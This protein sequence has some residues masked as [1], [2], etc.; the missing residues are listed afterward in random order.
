MPT[1]AILSGADS[2]IVPS[3]GRYV[4]RGTVTVFSDAEWTSL[5]AV[6]AT[7]FTL[8]TGGGGGGSGG[9]VTQGTAAALGGAWPVE[10]TDGSVVL[11]TSS[12]PLQVSGS[13]G[14]GP[15]SLPSGSVASGA[16]AVGSLA[17][18]SGV[19]G[20][21]V[22]EGSTTDSA[23]TTDIAGSISAR[24]RG[25]V[26][27]LVAR[28]PVALGGAGGLKVETQ[29]AVAVSATQ[30]G[31]AIDP[32]VIRAL[33]S[34]DQVTTVPS[35]TTVVS[36]VALPL[37]AGAA[38]AAKQ[39]AIGTAGTAAADVLSVQGV[40]G[41][42][43]VKTDGSAVTQPVSAAA[44]PLPASASQ[45]GTDAS[46]V[47]PPAGAV[48]I[49]GWLSSIWKQLA[50]GQATM[51]SSLPVAVASNQ[52]AIPVSGPIA[53]S[54]GAA[55]IGHVIADTGSTT[56]VTAL[57][58]IPAGGNVIGHVIADS[59]STTAVTSLPAIPAGTNVIGH[60][61][62]DSGSTTAVTSLPSL[63]AGTAVIGATLPSTGT[64]TDHSGTITTGGTAQQAVGANASR[65]Y[66]L[67]ANPLTATQILY[68]N[69]TASAVVGQPSIGLNPGDSFE[70]NGG[71]V[72]TEAV[73]V[74]GATTNN[75]F[76]CKDG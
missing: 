13:S 68:F 43:A 12:H 21:N 58:S 38:T 69:F 71:F 22:T 41:A 7:L 16:Y 24:L 59:G 52:S 32:R 42:T 63:V 76:V 29:S 2:I 1:T 17:T 64:I 11:G 18:G 4:D 53:L 49:R 56:A 15:A 70:M 40:A 50:W 5:S 60:V 9:T 67:I 34:A 61:V 35:G 73:S 20:W 8:G 3:S 51:A 28:L 19:D 33:T 23:V 31:A 65:K 44:L 62:A 72:T 36:A 25:L 37:P 27:V 57:P 39:P 46:G 48:G 10:I 30:G 14:G 54:S 6:Q 74:L 45:D 47:T 75:P 26:N 66:L 55:V